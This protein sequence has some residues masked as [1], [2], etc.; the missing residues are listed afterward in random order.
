MRCDQVRNLFDAYLDGELSSS[1]AT[2]IQSHCLRCADCGRALALA[3]VSASILAS[4]LNEPALRGDFTDRL[5]AC[6]RPAV[7]RNLIWRAP[8]WRRLACRRLVWWGGPMAA[9]AALVFSVVLWGPWSQPEPFMAVKGEVVIGEPKPAASPDSREP[10]SEILDEAE[11]ADPAAARPALDSLMAQFDQALN[12]RLQGG[13]TLRQ[14]LNAGVL[15]LA[16]HLGLGPDDGAGAGDPCATPSDPSA[17]N[18]DDP[19]E[20]L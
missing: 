13:Q 5:M 16:R 20:E 14:T 9:A 1:L 8:A 3:Q 4:D 7:R 15:N 12:V 18:P 10:V 17:D 11:T 2:E 6:I 19:L